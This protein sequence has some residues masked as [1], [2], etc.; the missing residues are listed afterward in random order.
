MCSNIDSKQS[1]DFVSA[2]NMNFFEIF[3]FPTLSLKGLHLDQWEQDE[4]FQ[5]PKQ[6]GSQHTG[7]DIA[8]RG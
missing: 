5:N 7:L 1:E 6:I 8:V 2:N 4:D 3:E